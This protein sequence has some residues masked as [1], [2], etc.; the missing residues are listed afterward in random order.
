[1][2]TLWWRLLDWVVPIL[3]TTDD[4][5]RAFGI[6]SVITYQ[7]HRDGRVTVLYDAFYALCHPADCD[8]NC[9]GERLP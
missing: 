3:K 1:M 7:E 8:E 4:R 9:P 6:R 5:D 2:K